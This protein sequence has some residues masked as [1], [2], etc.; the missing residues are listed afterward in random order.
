MPG[1]VSTD[2][3]ERLRFLNYQRDTGVP[4]HRVKWNWL[5]DLP[6]GKGRRFGNNAGAALDKFIGGW[7]VAGLGSLGSTYFAL[8]TSNWNFNNPVEI[9]GYK[10]PIENCT[11]GVC[12]PGYLWWNGYIPPNLINS[13]DAKGN[14]NGYEGIP[15]DYKPAATPLIP[16][17]QTALPPNAPAGTNVSTYWDTNTA[18]I[19]LNNGTVQR[20]TYDTGLNPWRNQYLPSV[21]QWGLD[22]SVFKM[23]PSLNGSTC[24][25]MRTSLTS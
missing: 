10:H 16:Y 22:A 4:Q 9:Y 25:S 23:V 5:V 21:M 6:F 8:P 12:V 7:Q 2:A 24:G 13:H 18:W 15:A 11:S 20:V 17:G 1:A 19:K 3:G 14:P